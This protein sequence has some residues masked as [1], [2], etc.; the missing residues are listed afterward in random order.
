[1]VGLLWRGVWTEYGFVAEL[2]RWARAVL[3]NTR[4]EAKLLCDGFG[5][6]ANNVSVVPNGVDERFCA[7]KPDAFRD[8]YDIDKFI[9]YVGQL[10]EGRKNTLT[11]IRI[12]NSMDVPAVIIG[13]SEDTAFADRCGVEAAR[14][15]RLVLIDA[16][17]NDSGLLASAYAACD[18]F[19]LPSLF[20]TPG[21]AA[22]EAAL[23]GA[24]IVITKYGGTEEYFASWA[25]FVD[26]RSERS[27]RRGIQTAL[28]KP[29]GS[30]LREHVRKNFLWSEVGKKTLEGYQMALHRI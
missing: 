22:L 12:L 7:A 4:A 8:R 6:S 26:P 23:A 18:V 20:E 30:E 19:V 11:L 9:L 28:S 27:I 21:L 14:N 3:P 13:Q 16:L 25:E 15:P 29:R 24:K 17:P 5:I 10:D 1:M 2:C